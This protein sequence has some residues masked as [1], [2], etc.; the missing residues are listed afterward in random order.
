MAKKKETEAYFTP[1]GIDKGTNGQIEKSVELPDPTDKSHKD[2][3]LTDEDVIKMYDLMFLQRRFEERA[4][5]M[6]QKGKFGGFLHL[7]I[8]QEAVSTGTVFALNGDDDIITAYRDHGWGLVRG[9]S[10]KSGMAELY[11]KATGCSK[12]KGGS[13][14]FAN[15]KEHFWG[16]Y[17]I[18]GGH[19]PIGGGIAFANKYQE[20][21]RVTATFLG[22]GA[23]DQGSLHETLNMSQLWG[24][25]CIYVVENNGYSMGTAARRHTVNEIHERAK[26]YGMKSAVFNG[27]DALTVYENMKKIS[28]EVRKDGM[29]WFVEVRTYRYR[30][31]SM[32]D[33]QKY[34]TKEELKEYQKVDP[35]ER[36]KSYLLDEKIAKKKDLEEIDQKVE[37]Q[38]LEAIEYAENSD[39][40]EEEALYEDMFADSP[41]FHD[42]K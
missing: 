34:R 30:G 27:M 20:N 15:V 3:G 37:D 36:M 39:F 22:D 33:P 6:Y 32:S 21:D 41:H 13:M 7:Y 24:L 28:D 42:R 18:V 10:P 29:P 12:G 35:I 19:V 2:L 14:H 23:V 40:P 5:Q 26:G 11:G 4:M 31:H 17:G 1:I 8:G 16:G 9:I 38:V 25:P